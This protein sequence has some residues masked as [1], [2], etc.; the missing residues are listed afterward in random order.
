MI[1]ITLSNKKKKKNFNNSKKEKVVCFLC[2]QTHLSYSSY[3]VL[4]DIH[5]YVS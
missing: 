4:I 5:M 2:V 3:Y 1:I